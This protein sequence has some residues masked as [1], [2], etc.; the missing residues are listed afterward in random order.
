[1]N[2]SS[3]S[4]SE[5]VHAIVLQMHK[6][7]NEDS[8]PAWA[9][10]SSSGEYLYGTA[11]YADLMANQTAVQ[12][13]SVDSLSI[14]DATIADIYYKDKLT[15]EQNKIL[16]SPEIFMLNGKL[17]IAEVRRYP[18]LDKT[19]A[20]AVGVIVTP[21]S[22]LKLILDK[23]KDHS[24]I[25]EPQISGTIPFFK[26]RDKLI[27]IMVLFDLTV[28]E[29]ATLLGVSVT[30]ISGILGRICRSKFGMPG[31][32]RHYREKLI[33]L[34]IYKQFLWELSGSEYRGLLLEAYQLSF[35]KKL[36][37]L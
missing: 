5:K 2:L 17:T 26:L 7:I 16:I 37:V 22:H 34:G 3:S 12:G 25:Q 10:R 4:L 28:R 36:F 30:R 33:S 1:M 31:G 21:L 18:L 35:F 29:I 32:G 11:K 13:N 15:L 19:E 20:V 6:Y 24:F 23:Y 27:G 14:D 8:T 9:I